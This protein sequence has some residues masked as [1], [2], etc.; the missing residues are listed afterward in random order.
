MTI[1]IPNAAR[2]KRIIAILSSII[3]VQFLCIVFLLG[4][5]VNPFDVPSPP[6]TITVSSAFTPTPMQTPTATPTPSTTVTPSATPTMTLTPTPTATL[7]LTQGFCHGIIDVGNPMVLD[8][9]RWTDNVRIQEV[10]RR[11]QIGDTI[12][13]SLVSEDGAY[14]GFIIPEGDN[15]TQPYVIAASD[16]DIQTCDVESTL[17]RLQNN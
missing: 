6:A 10:S 17:G 4:A 12:I 2:Y 11:L 8:A 1:I 14:L 13:V 9:E 15:P 7:T 5:L 3:V 16:V